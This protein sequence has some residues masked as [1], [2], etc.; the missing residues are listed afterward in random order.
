MPT[1]PS[2]GTINP[3]ESSYYPLHLRLPLYGDVACGQQA[4]HE[5][6]R[7]WVMR[8][9]QRATSHTPCVKTV[10][11]S[12][13]PRL[14][15]AFLVQRYGR[16]AQTFSYYE[17]HLSSLALQPAAL[18][19]SFKVTWADTSRC[20]PDLLRGPCTDNWDQVDLH[21]IRL[22]V[23]SAAPSSNAL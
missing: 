1:P 2:S 4:S 19:V 21:P 9:A 12:V 23:L 18:H 14:L 5:A 8:L 3:A 7:P 6:S 16:H 10:P 11:M 17:A 13:D 15:P 20:Q 22:A